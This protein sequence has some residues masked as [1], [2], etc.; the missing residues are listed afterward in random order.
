MSVAGLAG[1][2]EELGA[3]LLIPGLAYEGGDRPQV[4]PPSLQVRLDESL[5]HLL[6]APHEQLEVAYAG[7][8]LHGYEHPT[9]HLEESVLRGGQ[10][11]SPEVLADLRVIYHAAGIQIQEPF[12]PDHLGAM[13]ALMGYLLDCLEEA[14]AQA[15]PELQQA[16]SHLLTG[17]LVPLQAHIAEGLAQRKAPPYYRCV[18]DLLGIALEALED[19]NRHQNPGLER[20][21]A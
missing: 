18:L 6:E 1:L 10:L 11:R 8:F 2:L 4:E 16:A 12:E 7:L 19:M 13:A 5:Q 9:L 21:L 15:S 14:G 3:S 17:H 20:C